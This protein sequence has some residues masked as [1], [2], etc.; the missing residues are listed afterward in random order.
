MEDLSFLVPVLL[1]ALICA[2]ARIMNG[3]TARICKSRISLAILRSPGIIFH[4]FSHA[5][6]CILTGADIREIVWYNPEDG[7]GKV[8]HGAPRI[9]VL[10]NFIISVAPFFGILLLFLALGDI[11]SS[12]AGVTTDQQ[13]NLTILPEGIF[14]LIGSSLQIFLQNIVYSPNPWFILYLYLIISILPGLSPSVPDLWN[15]DVGI[16]IIGFIA[17]LGLILYFQGTWFADLAAAIQSPILPV[18][19]SV[20]LAEILALAVMVP[21]YT[22]CR[23]ARN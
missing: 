5:A 6:A 17:L 1:V 22:I 10:G 15:L 18:L 23:Y 19:T 3:I 20:L 2:F 7:S 9:P 14:A 16:V 4:E 13:V 21:V 12:F 8:V 11:F